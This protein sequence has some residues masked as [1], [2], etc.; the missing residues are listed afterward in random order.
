MNTSIPIQLELP[1]AAEARSHEELSALL[2][3]PSARRTPVPG[4]HL[5]LTRNRATMISL[6]TDAAGV[7]RLRMH[8]AFAAAPLALLLDLRHYIRTRN[9]DAWRRVAAFARGIR[10]RA[11]AD[12]SPALRSSPLGPRYD[13]EIIRREINRQF[14]SGRVDCS[15]VWGRRPPRRRPGAR[16]CHLRLGSWCPSRR[17][18]RVHP[19][20]DRETAPEFF[21]R[22]IVYHEMLHA[23]VPPVRQGTRTVFHT[24]QFRALEKQFPQY[25]AARAFARDVERLATP[26]P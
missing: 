20:L 6:R 2:N 1:L 12:G 21:V 7:R 10:T 15:I 14:F 24:P 13:L 18:I 26:S 25:A 8:E 19:C 4:V 16:S 23:V 3:E 11:P 9:R 17:L 22:F 5:V